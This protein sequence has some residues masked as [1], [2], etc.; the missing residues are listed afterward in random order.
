MY[1]ERV[2]RTNHTV[3]ELNAIYYNNPKLNPE[4]EVAKSFLPL[5]KW[6]WGNVYS[7]FHEVSYWRKFNA[8]HN[9]FVNNVQNGVDDCGRYELTKEKIEECVSLLEKV[10]ETGNHELLEPKSGFFFGSTEI[11]ECYWS[12]IDYSI[13]KLKEILLLDWE[14]YRFF[15]N[16][17]W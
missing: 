4:S 6:D 13:I 1:I 9:W 12:A 5:Y 17:S 14:A 7:I 15:Y 8:L 10:R 16:S 2:N 11:D 3:E